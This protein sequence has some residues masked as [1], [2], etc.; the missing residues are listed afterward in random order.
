M[1]LLLACLFVVATAIGSYVAFGVAGALL[2]PS[3]DPGSAG[4]AASAHT[5][6]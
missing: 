1:I 6:L 2:H 4:S 5:Q 3:A